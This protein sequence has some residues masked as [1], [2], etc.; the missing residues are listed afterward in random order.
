M[1]WLFR[2][3]V[4]ERP[5]WSQA[6]ASGVKVTAGFGWVE[7]M[8][9]EAAPSTAA[10]KSAASGRDDT[11]FVWDEEFRSKRERRDSMA[12]L[13]SKKGTSCAMCVGMSCEFAVV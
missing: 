13:S 8:G 4:A 3:T 6:G 10:A 12:P 9:R 11:S 1:G 5:G 2:R 7:G